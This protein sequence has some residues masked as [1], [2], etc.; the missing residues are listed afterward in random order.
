ME[1]DAGCQLLTIV[2][3]HGDNVGGRV[4]GRCT[5]VK[6]GV[7]AKVRA[8]SSASFNGADRC[9]EVGVNREGQTKFIEV[10]CCVFTGTNCGGTA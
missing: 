1:L 9:R 7:T 6:G 8:A 2:G 10:Q 3:F 5:V 4:K